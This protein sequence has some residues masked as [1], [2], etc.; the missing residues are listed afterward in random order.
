[1]GNPPLST[2]VLHLKPHND[3]SN[4]DKSTL[5]RACEGFDISS[6]TILSF[7]LTRDTDKE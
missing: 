3:V 6:D 4:R 2:F 1:M 7:R 5:G